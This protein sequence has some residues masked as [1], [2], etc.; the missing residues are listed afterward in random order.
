MLVSLDI[1]THNFS[2]IGKYISN[3]LHHF[4]KPRTQRAREE[5]KKPTPTLNTSLKPKTE[6]AEEP[7]SVKPSKSFPRKVLPAEPSVGTYK[8]NYTIIDK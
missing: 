2:K 8:V 5:D 3:K 4:H 7:Q 1:N 6:P